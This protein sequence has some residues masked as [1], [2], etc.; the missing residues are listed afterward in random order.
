MDISKQR[1]LL[2]S[3][4]W[5]ASV[6]LIVFIFIN[7]FLHTGK[8]KVDI[9]TVPTDSKISTPFGNLKQGINY[10]PYGQYNFTISRDGF[11]NITTPVTVTKELSRLPLAI[12]PENE[13]GDKYL[14][15]NPEETTRY[16]VMG[17]AQS[18]KVSVEARERYPVVMQL[19]HRSLK[20][21]FTINY[22][23][24]ETSSQLVYFVIGKSSTKGRLSAVAWLKEKG[25][26]ISNADI[27]YGEFTS[28]LESEITIKDLER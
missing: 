9:L 3:L 21:N 23:V 24:D 7:I 4:L 15:D 8:Q 12:L 22:G 10:L 5:L 26:D 17:A 2:I 6:A 25:I 11:K 19:P 16:E 18:Q 27:R 14:E 20:D 28:P 13:I 1:T